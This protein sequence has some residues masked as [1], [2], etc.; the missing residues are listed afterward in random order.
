PA[1]NDPVSSFLPNFLHPPPP[2]HRR[3][4]SKR[5]PTFLPSKTLQRRR[6]APPPKTLL[7]FPVDQAD[8]GSDEAYIIVSSC[9][10]MLVTSKIICFFLHR[11]A[12][13]FKHVLRKQHYQ[14][15]Y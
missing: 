10:K 1:P 5:Q 6:P 13:Y 4:A 15:N 7:R 8:D 9:R 12:T 3:V 2:G 11:K 14:R